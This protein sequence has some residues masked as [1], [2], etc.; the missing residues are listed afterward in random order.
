MIEFI[1]FSPG[2]YAGALILFWGITVLLA[3]VGLA[4]Q[5]KPLAV[6]FESFAFWVLA[7]I[8]ILFAAIRQF[9]IAPDDLAYLEIYKGICPSMDC[10]QWIQGSR[11]WGWYSLIGLLKSLWDT[12]RTLLFVAGIAAVIKLWV[13][14]KLSSRPLWA[15]LCFV[16]IFYLVQDLTALRVSW[17][18]AFFMLAIYWLSRRHRIIGSLTLFLPGLIHLQ[19]IISPMIFVAAMLRTRYYIFA[20]LAVTPP[21]LVLM[22]LYPLLYK[23][24]IAS[25]EAWTSYPV[26]KDVI[27]DYIAV[28]NA[29][30]YHQIRALPYTFIPLILLIVGFSVEVFK[31]HRSLYIYC[32]MSFVIACWSLWIFAGWREPQVRFF[33][34]FALP[35]VLLV[36]NFRAGWLQFLSVVLASGVF[37][38][39]YDL[40]HPFLLG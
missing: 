12:P 24:N 7:I 1:K 19:A 27:S 21:L 11:D 13:I 30:N 39:R 2:P 34:Y 40:L 15:L 28:T 18:L 32:A 29:E 20:L 6:Y 9:G 23:S 22:G 3:A 31:N 8:L 14:F 25:W 38:I 4:I 36:G 37:V 10:K 16:P 35:A 26:L 5:T 33:E 17:A